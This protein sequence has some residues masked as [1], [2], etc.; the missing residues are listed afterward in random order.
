MSDQAGGGACDGRCGFAT[1]VLGAPFQMLR[2]RRG[3]AYDGG[4][5]PPKEP[6]FIYLGARSD[7]VTYQLDPASRERLRAVQGARP[8]NRVF[9]AYDTKA[10]GEQEHEAFDQQ[11]VQLLTGLS[12]ERLAELGGVEL[13]D[14]RTQTTTTLS[15]R[16]AA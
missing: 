9:I 7:G 15:A 1:G 6:I 10:N 14:P 8:V 4:V 3:R 13:Y 2:T 5:E 16:S 12:A 11:A